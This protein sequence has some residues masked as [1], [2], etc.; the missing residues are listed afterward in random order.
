MIGFLVFVGL[1]WLA[2]A[3]VPENWLEQ[4]LGYPEREA[5]TGRCK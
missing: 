1:L 5:K 2:H 3:L 4:L